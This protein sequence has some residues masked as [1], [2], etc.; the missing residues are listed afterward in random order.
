MGRIRR[1]RA[2]CASRRVRTGRSGVE[3]TPQGDGMRLL[4]WTGCLRS[5]QWLASSEGERE[6]DRPDSRG[7]A[8]H[9]R[10]G[11]RCGGA[12]A[13]EPM[14]GKVTATASGPCLPHGSH[15]RRICCSC[16]RSSRAATATS[17]STS[18]VLSRI[19]TYW[20]QVPG[21]DAAA[22]APR[23]VAY[24]GEATH[25][26][27]QRRLSTYD[28]MILPTLGENF[29]HIIVEAWAAGCPVLISDRTPW[30]RLEGAGSWAGTCRW[31]TAHG[32][33]RSAS[34]SR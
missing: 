30:R 17:I 34:A 27:L 13:D 19:R 23:S 1:A 9:V 5:I 14:A 32:S 26:D 25:R 29:G 2:A 18:S 12:G 4:R 6:R 28:V 20:A 33:P 22:A 15:R 31:I 16:W 21:H 8:D 24:T 3:A 7:I 10:A 11:E